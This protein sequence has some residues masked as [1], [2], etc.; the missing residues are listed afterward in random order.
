[1][2]DEQSDMLAFPHKLEINY[3]ET[4]RHLEINI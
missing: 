2:E 1:M 4:T 3:W